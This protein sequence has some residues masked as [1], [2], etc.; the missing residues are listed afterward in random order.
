[1]ALAV[2]GP[3]ALP[4]AGGGGVG[5]SQAGV[6]VAELVQTVARPTAATIKVDQGGRSDRVD[7]RLD[8]VSNPPGGYAVT[9]A[10][11]VLSR[12]DLPITLEG[13]PSADPSLVL[14]LP[15]SPTLAPAGVPLA[16]GH[17]TGS[18][19]SATGDGWRLRMVVGPI[20]CPETGIHD[21]ELV[22]ETRAGTVSRTSRVMLS[23]DVRRNRKLCG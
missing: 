20:G 3:W 11:T 15:V 23:V 18:I 10:R 21:G 2:L 16:L 14:D 19:S 4:A 8:V 17:R 9:V 1:M 7:V 6:V 13:V 5:E 12:G 22:F